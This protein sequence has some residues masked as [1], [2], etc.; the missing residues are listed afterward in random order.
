MHIIQLRTHYEKHSTSGILLVKDRFFAYTLED[1]MR[2]VRLG[3]K[4][5]G[6]TAIPAGIYPLAVTK[7]IKFGRQMP[8]IFHVPGFDGIRIHGGNTVQD[9]L[10][11]PL[12]ARYRLSW[13]RI[14]KSK[15]REL[16][17]LLLSKNEEHR[18][19]IINAAPGY[20]YEA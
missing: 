12:I 15:E 2:P 11:C 14:W 7:S 10:G 13:F 6:A 17:K 16:T 19:E 4:V 9:S 8:Q 1:V 20:Y 5:Y 18:I 3:K